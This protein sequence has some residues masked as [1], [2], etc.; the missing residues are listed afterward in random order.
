MSLPNCK[1]AALNARLFRKASQRPTSHGI[2]AG[3]VVECRAD[4][5]VILDDAFIPTVLRCGGGGHVLR[6]S[7]PNCRGL[8][9]QRGDAL[10]ARAVATGAVER[11]RIADFLLLQTHQ[12]PRAGRD[13]SGVRGRLPSGGVISIVAADGG[14]LST[15]TSATRRPSQISRLRHNALRASFEPVHPDL[16]TLL[17][18]VLG[19]MPSRFRWSRK[20]S[21]SR[22]ATDLTA[23]CSTTP[24]SCWPRARS[25]RRGNARPLPMQLKVDRSINRDLVEPA[26][27][28]GGRAGHGCRAIVSFPTTRDLS[29]S[30]WIRGGEL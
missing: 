3:A 30:S 9:H 23:R 16:R 29:T 17:S 10:A 28:R 14:D 25:G 6:H 27:I 12:P 2:A 7:C 4:G 22:L 26:A 15:L 13:S 20:N 1:V 21:A 8:L 11:R 19:A 18:V 24:C 5:H